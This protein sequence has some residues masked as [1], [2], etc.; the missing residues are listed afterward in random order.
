MSCHVAPL[1]TVSTRRSASSDI[2][3]KPVMSSTTP[4]RANAWPPML[5]LTPAAEIFGPRARANASACRTSSGDFTATTPKTG[6]RLRQLASFTVPPSCRQGRSRTSAADGA[7]GMDRASASR[8]PQ[9]LGPTGS[10]AS[11]AARRRGNT[12]T[13]RSTSARAA[14]SRER[15][16]PDPGSDAVE[17]V[18]AGAPGVIQVLEQPRQLAKHRCLDPA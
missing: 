18:G 15:T 4:E 12:T 6:V 5:C 11:C 9:S 7:A 8:G 2:R 16:R 1:P 3:L 10:A 13:S 14:S 17:T